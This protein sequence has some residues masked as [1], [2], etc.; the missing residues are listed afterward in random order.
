MV[1]MLAAGPVVLWFESRSGQTKDYN[2]G[3][4]CFFD[5]YA[6]LSRKSKDSSARIQDNVSEWGDCGQ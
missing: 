2:I 5:K 6:A 3:I 1:S 4:C